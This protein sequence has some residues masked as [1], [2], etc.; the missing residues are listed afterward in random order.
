M[1]FRLRS[2]GQQEIYNSIEIENLDLAVK[3]WSQACEQLFQCTA[4]DTTGLLSCKGKA[5]LGRGSHRHTKTSTM[6]VPFCKPGRQGD[7]QPKGNWQHVQLRQLLR[8][9]RRLTSLFHLTRILQQD[10]SIQRRS[11]L[12]HEI[13]S[14]WKASTQ[15]TGFPQSFQ[16]FL[17]EQGAF[18]ALVDLPNA[19]FVTYIG[20]VNFL[21]ILKGSTWLSCA[22]RDH[23]G[24]LKRGGRLVFQ[25]LKEDTG[26]LPPVFQK[27]LPFE[28]YRF[29]VLWTHTESSNYATPQV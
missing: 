22:E 19:D 28:I 5:F 18:Y 25:S 15:S 14:L 3:S 29:V 9:V 2:E 27:K 6:S 12:I 20:R 8:Q 4:V 16:T 10:L 24:D 13:T 17:F 26:S 11:C 21:T 7:F 1:L 23:D